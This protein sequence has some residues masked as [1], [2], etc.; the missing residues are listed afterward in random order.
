MEEDTIQ[1]TRTNVLDNGMI[2]PR[3]SS[4]AAR[5][6]AGIP[7]ADR[8]AN[9]L[10]AL[11]TLQQREDLPCNDSILKYSLEAMMRYLP[12][13]V[14]NSIYIGEVPGEEEDFSETVSDA[15]FEA[16]LTRRWPV[17]CDT[18]TFAKTCPYF[19][20]P[21]NT[22][23]GHYVTLIAVLGQNEEKVAERVKA[24]EDPQ[25]AD[26]KELKA[27]IPW[28]EIVQWSIVDPKRGLLDEDGWERDMNEVRGKQKHEARLERIRKRVRHIL[29][30]G[31]IKKWSAAL[32]A[33][34]EDW[35]YYSWPWVP[36]QTDNWSS[37]FRS[38]ALIKQQCNAVLN[39]HC[40]N[41]I[42][43]TYS[44]WKHSIGWLNPHAVRHEM[45]GLLAMGCIRDMKWQ[46]R[47]AI[48]PIHTMDGI[49][50]NDAFPADL[51]RPTSE[52]KAYVSHSDLSCAD[53]T[54]ES[55]PSRVDHYERKGQLRGI[56]AMMAWE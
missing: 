47:I 7:E 48:E 5:K 34:S 31:G 28:D 9:H 26:S 1:W 13:E 15:E 43:N 33:Q 46:A 29:E 30:H 17:D 2:R 49:E 56:D 11:N 6:E 37:G 45:M 14:F 16:N 41:K 50:G 10:Y 42:W 27:P 20:W 51:L 39:L 19:F 32:Y 55:D 53:R 18:F 4:K 3:P 24:L 23:G 54:T 38:F 22:G 8:A 36:P 44:F 40:L 21:I 52:V 12:D 35:H 25:R